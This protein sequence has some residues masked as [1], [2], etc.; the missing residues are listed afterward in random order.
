MIPWL[1]LQQYNLA[2]LGLSEWSNGWFENLD[3]EKLIWLEKKTLQMQID[4][5]F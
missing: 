4:S 5:T 2:N 3:V 1:G